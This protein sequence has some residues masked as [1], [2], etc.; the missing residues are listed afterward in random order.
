[1]QKIKEKKPSKN[2]KQKQKQQQQQQNKTTTTKQNK[3]KATFI[4]QHT[5]NVLIEIVVALILVKKE[6]ISFTLP[7]LIR[8]M[9]Y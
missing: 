5:C 3:D 6:W 9:I 1:M 8:F 2:K 7:S 4:S